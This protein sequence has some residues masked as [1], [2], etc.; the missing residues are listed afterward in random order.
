[1]GLFDKLKAK[2]NFGMGVALETGKGT[3]PDFGEIEIMRG[4]PRPHRI[5][6]VPPH[7]CDL[8]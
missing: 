7:G 6:K 8:F 3:A 5:K 4:V 2:F 1:M